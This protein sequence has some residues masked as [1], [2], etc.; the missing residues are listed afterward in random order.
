MAN[1][2]KTFQW[3]RGR[4]VLYDGPTS[5]ISIGPLTIYIYNTS[6]TTCVLYNTAALNLKD[7]NIPS[8]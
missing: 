2:L 1:P 6:N 7:Y 8:I 5:G 4:M 3:T